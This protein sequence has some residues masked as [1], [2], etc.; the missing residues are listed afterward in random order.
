MRSSRIS[1]SRNRTTRLSPQGQYLAAASVLFLVL[2]GGNLPTPLYPLWQQQ[3]GLN[4][5]TITAVY[6]VYPAGVVLGLLFG[7]RFA[8]QIGRRPVM[9]LAALASVLA[10]ACFI[11]ATSV[12]LLFAGRLIN[13]CAIGLLSGTAVAAIAELNPEGDRKKGAWVGA[14]TTVMPIAFGPLLAALLVRF[15]PVPAM[16]SS[17]PFVVHMVA[18]ALALILVATCLHETAPPSNLRSWRDV[19]L[20]PQGIAVPLEIRSRFRLAAACLRWA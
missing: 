9:A 6:A 7:G 17:F 2:F 14:L 1:T 15:P 13:G 12:G 5:G 16:K 11:M 18:L 4:T 3:F 19:S 20:V 8:D 10:E